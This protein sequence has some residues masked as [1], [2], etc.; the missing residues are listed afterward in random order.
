MTF[1]LDPA[2]PVPPDGENPIRDMNPY[3]YEGAN[4]MSRAAWDS[5]YSVGFA[6]GRAAA[7][8]RCD[9][10]DEPFDGQCAACRAEDDARHPQD[11]FDGAGCC[12]EED[13]FLRAKARAAATPDLRFED[14]AD[15]MATPLDF[16]RQQEAHRSDCACAMCVVLRDYIAAKSSPPAASP[17]DQPVMANMC[18]G[19]SPDH[20][21]GITAAATP[22]APDEEGWSPGIDDP[23]PRA[24]G[25][26]E[27]GEGWYQT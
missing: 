2:A 11:E 9:A 4:L 17:D 7:T 27:T 20:K 13:G 19:E 14:I 16:R 24:L 8:P 21:P 1:P 6:A 5:G 3:R 18:E 15:R 26:I 25:D 22:E 10:C 12:P 23:E